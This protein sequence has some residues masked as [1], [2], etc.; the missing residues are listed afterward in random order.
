MS[1]EKHRILE[2]DEEQCHRLLANNEQRLGRVAFAEGGDANWPTVLPVNYAYH[3]GAVYFRTFEGSKLY[4]ALRHQRVAF[5]VDRINDEWREG[6][7]VVALGPLDIVR[8]PD[9]VAVLDPML[10]SWATG[11]NEQLVRLGI[12]RISGREVIGPGTGG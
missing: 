8:D 2:V 11:S 10:T 9:V 7:S 12:E 4:A 1:R 3:D 5:E 6:W